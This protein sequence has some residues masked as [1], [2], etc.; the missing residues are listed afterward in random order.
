MRDGLISASCC[1]ISVEISTGGRVGIRVST[2]GN[3]S[4]S[5][6]V[7]LAHFVRSGFSHRIRS[8]RLRINSTKLATPFGVLHRCRGGVNGSI[9]MLATKNG[10]RYKI[11]ISTSRGRFIIRRA[12]VLHGINSG[13]GGPCAR[14]IHFNCSSMGSIGCSLGFWK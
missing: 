1:L 7:T 8:C 13:H 2:S 14:R 5:F 9:R 11:L 6:Y 10:G 3:I 12:L 4:V